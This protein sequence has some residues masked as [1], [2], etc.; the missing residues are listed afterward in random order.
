MFED[1]PASTGTLAGN[2]RTI[3][4]FAAQFCIYPDYLEGDCKLYLTFRQVMS[5]I[6]SITA[7]PWRILKVM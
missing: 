7:F 3:E 2:E 4:C 5:T 6:T 1:L